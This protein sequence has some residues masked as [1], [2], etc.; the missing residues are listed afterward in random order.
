MVR[1]RISIFAI[2]FALVLSLS[3]W[4]FAA[5]LIGAGFTVVPKVFVSLFFASLL[6]LARQL[7]LRDIFLDS[8]QARLLLYVFGFYIFITF[9]SVIFTF[10]KL[11]WGPDTLEGV[12]VISGITAGMFFFSQFK[13]RNQIIIVVFLITL[14]T[15]I[16]FGVAQWYLKPDFFTEEG[17]FTYGALNRWWEL[18]A[19]WGQYSFS[20]KNVFGLSIVFPLAILLPLLSS[21]LISKLKVSLIWILVISSAPVLYFSQSRTSFSL[22]F[23][24]CVNTYFQNKTYLKNKISNLSMVLL[25]L[26]GTLYFLATILPAWIIRSNSEQTRYDALRLAFGSEKTNWFFGGGFN[27]VYFVTAPTDPLGAFQLSGNQG[28][29]VDIFFIRRW[30]ETGLIGEISLLLFI[31]SLF[32]YSSHKI[33]AVP[34]LKKNELWR[35]IASRNL[36]LTITV[37]SVSGDFLSFQIVAILSALCMSAIVFGE[38]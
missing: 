36:A 10:S 38:D 18:S 4:Y 24:L 17:F 21:G 33:R 1:D 12:K 13:N 22:F 32:S 29:V 34:T 19:I 27:S 16:F 8:A 28:S 6:V 26:G 9:I 30:I 3:Q 37:S 15:S 25:S 7:I 2:Y 31:Y 20:G 5:D 35:P 11:G 23:L 14:T